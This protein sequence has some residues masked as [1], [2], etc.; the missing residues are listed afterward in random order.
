VTERVGR[1]R[2]DHD[3]R[4]SDWNPVAEDERRGRS[5]GGD[6]AVDQQLDQG[7]AEVVGGV[8]GDQEAA[9][10]EELNGR[11]RA[12][13]DTADH[14][15]RV[16]PAGDRDRLRVANVSGVIDG[17]RGE[18]DRRGHVGNAVRQAAGR[19]LDDAEAHAVGECL[20]ARDRTGV[21]AFDDDVDQ[22]TA[23]LGRAGERRDDPRDGCRGVG[24]DR[25]GDVR[26]ADVA[27]EVRGLHHDRQL[28]ARRRDVD[29]E[30]VRRRRIEQELS[31]GLL[32]RH[33]GHADVVGGVDGDGDLRSRLDRRL[34]HG[35]DRR[36]AEVVDE[37]A[38]LA[39]EEP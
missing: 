7:D 28:R 34:T 29:L 8:D 35:D 37:R 31:A 23:G 38:P 6:L 15:R 13:A 9:V 33:A 20:D 32:Q 5:R 11:A 17:A 21:S 26:R 24:N 22:R 36:V 1:A 25:Q 16:R 12:D 39:D 10:R 2:G 27:A 4:F 14:R 30:G 19:A 3:L 18:R